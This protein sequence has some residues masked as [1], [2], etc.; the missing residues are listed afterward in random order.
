MQAV[1]LEHM[2][3]LV[4]EYH[5][6]NVLGSGPDSREGVAAFLD[7]RDPQ[8]VSRVSDGLPGLPGW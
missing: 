4:D 5:S 1:H 2:A 8:W 6:F 3:L 7:K